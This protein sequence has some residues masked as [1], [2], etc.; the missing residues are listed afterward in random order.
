ME[1]VS[2]KWV[3]TDTAGRA[4]VEAALQK[5][6]KPDFITE[7]G[8]QEPKQAPQEKMALAWLA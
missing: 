3:V 5:G 6:T 7:E 4:K 8:G 1:A 2:S